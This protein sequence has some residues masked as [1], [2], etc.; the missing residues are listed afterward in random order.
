MAVVSR[1]Y[2]FGGGCRSSILNFHGKPIILCM[3]DLVG[4]GGVFT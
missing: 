3:E 2:H 1:W 4:M